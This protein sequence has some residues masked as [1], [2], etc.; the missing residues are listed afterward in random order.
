M[1]IDKVDV[2]YKLMVYQKFLTEFVLIYWKFWR[3]ALDRS[4]TAGEERAGDAPADM[5]PSLD[6]GRFFPEK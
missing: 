5:P 4:E 6:L 1:V 3:D 2:S